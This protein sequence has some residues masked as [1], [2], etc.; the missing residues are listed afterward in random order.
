MGSGIVAVRRADPIEDR[1]LS[2]AEFHRS[3]AKAK[4]YVDG[5][6]QALGIPTPKRPEYNDEIELRLGEKRLV[7]N[8]ARSIE[9]TRRSGVP[10]LLQYLF[11]SRDRFLAPT[12][13]MGAGRPLPGLSIDVTSSVGSFTKSIEAPGWIESPEL[14]LS[15]DILE[16]RQ[17]VCDHSDPDRFQDATR[18]YRSYLQTC[19]SLIDCFLFRYTSFVKG[20][21]GDLEEYANT[22]VLGSPVGIERRI[23]AWVLTFATTHLSEYKSTAEWSQF[24][25]LR[26][27]RNSFVHP[28]EPAVGYQPKEMAR[29]L[30]YCNLGIGGLL[31]NFRRYGE[32]DERI[33]FIQ[34]LTTAPKIEST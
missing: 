7:L 4:L 16:F 28:F 13:E 27:E 33:G 22:K 31:A 11:D 12:L 34:R 3:P 24:R 23:E 8:L 5:L 26:R 9:E 6:A 30:N 19:I 15:N 29:Y 25:E 18:F 21:I 2:I 14:S 32:T 20:K 1:L 17:L 10:K